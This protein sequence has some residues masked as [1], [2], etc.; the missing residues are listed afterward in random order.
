[1]KFHDPDPEYTGTPSEDEDVFDT[2]GFMQAVDAESLTLEQFVAEYGYAPDELR[3]RSN[4]ELSD[5]DWSV[6]AEPKDDA[7]RLPA[8][9]QLAVE[10]HAEEWAEL[11]E[12]ART[13][14]L[15][16]VRGRAAALDH[17]TADSNGNVTT[18]RRTA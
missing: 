11:S 14:R 17:F 13:V 4:E 1:V 7:L 5:A 15:A 10:R 6:L 8:G 3:T 2:D 18:R 16:R 9:V 12:D